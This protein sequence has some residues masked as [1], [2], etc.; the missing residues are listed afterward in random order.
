MFGF[1]SPPSIK[2]IGVG[3]QVLV[4]AHIFAEHPL[5]HISE[6]SV[7]LL[8]SLYCEHP[9]V[10]SAEAAVLHLCGFRVCYANVRD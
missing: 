5:V 8:L 6:T 3:G 1:G 10:L 4:R 2:S 7:L 9:D